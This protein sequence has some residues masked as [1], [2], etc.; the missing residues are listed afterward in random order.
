M[1]WNCPNDQEQMVMV[2]QDARESGWVEISFCNRC[3]EVIVQRY[4]SS[5]CPSGYQEFA[6]PAARR[7]ESPNQ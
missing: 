5:R 6:P 1:P 2:F 3:T 7:A 4:E